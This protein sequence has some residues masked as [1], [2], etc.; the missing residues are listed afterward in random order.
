MKEHKVNCMDNFIMGWYADDTSFCDELVKFHKLNLKTNGTFSVDIKEST[1]VSILLHQPTKYWD[2]L[3]ACWKL[4]FKKYTAARQNCGLSMRQPALIQHYPVGG[5][6]KVWHTERGTDTVDNST[7][8]LVFMTYINDVP[9]GG[10]EFMYQNLKIKAEKGLT[11]I[12]P[13]DWTFTHKSEISTTMEKWIIT[14]WINLKD[15][16]ENRNLL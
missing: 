8:H 11:V 16:N 12:W 3:S 9:D 5:G 6:F 7:R 15:E 13:A 14:G 1:D 2:H 10:T 4:Y